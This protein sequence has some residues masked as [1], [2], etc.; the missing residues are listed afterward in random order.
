VI[1]AW[2]KVWRDGI[3]PQLTVAGL[4]ALARA[5]EADDPR[6]LQWDTVNPPPLQRYADWPAEGACAVAYAAAIRPDGLPTVGETEEAF[7]DVCFAADMTLGERS[8]VRY[9]LN[10]WDDTDR[11]VARRDLLAEVRLAL[12]QRQP[13]PAA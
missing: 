13:A 6:L 9:F 5:L 8:A 4:E 7:A 12:Q 2:R 11:A 1:E 3:A 10:H